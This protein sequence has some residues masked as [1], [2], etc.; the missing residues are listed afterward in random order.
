MITILNGVQEISN[1]FGLTKKETTR[2]LNTPGCP[3]LPRG[4]NQ[5]YR[6]IAEEVEHW[7]RTRKAGQ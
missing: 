2:Y 4:K 6:V 1:Y 7:L 5:T 3:V